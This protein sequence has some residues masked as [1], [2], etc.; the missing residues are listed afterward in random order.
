MDLL[1]SKGLGGSIKDV[2]FKKGTLKKQLLRL[3]HS[4]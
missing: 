1:H 4:K 3:W 2:Y